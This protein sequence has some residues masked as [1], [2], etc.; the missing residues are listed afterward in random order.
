PPR[1]PD[2]VRRG[3]V[4][5]P[6]RRIWCRNGPRACEPD[7]PC[8]CPPRPERRSCIDPPTTPRC[9]APPGV[10]LTRAA[11]PVRGVA[12]PTLNCTCPCGARAHQGPAAPTPREVA[13]C[14]VTLPMPPPYGGPPTPRTPRTP[15]FLR[16][17]A[18][19]RRCPG[20]HPTRTHPHPPPHRPR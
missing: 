18:Q 19:I 20:G 9:R 4:G 1:S 6:L 13:R 8:L 5:S 10:G 11:T 12:A 2:L 14:F 7:P 3:G 17:S 15:R 16:R